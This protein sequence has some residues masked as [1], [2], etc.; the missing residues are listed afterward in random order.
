MI[1]VIGSHVFI[2]LAV[3]CSQLPWVSLT[4]IGSVAHTLQMVNSK[5]TLH[6]S[7]L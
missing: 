1:N 7:Q 6:A 3:V 4:C 5:G 2:Y